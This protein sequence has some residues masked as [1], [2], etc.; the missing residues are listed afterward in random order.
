[1]NLLPL[2]VESPYRLTLEAK[3][4]TFYVFQDQ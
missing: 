1:L 4:R 2:S 3:S